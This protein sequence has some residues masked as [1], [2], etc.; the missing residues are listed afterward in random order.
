MQGFYWECIGV[1]CRS[2]VRFGEITPMMENQMS[3]KME[4]EIGTGMA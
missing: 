1:L 3:H 2:Y 4:N